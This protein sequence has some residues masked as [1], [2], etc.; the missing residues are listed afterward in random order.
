MKKILLFSLLIQAAL[1]G[2]PNII[3]FLSDDHRADLLGCAG[4]PIL[5][6]PTIDALAARGVRFEN[7]FVTTA[8]CAASRATIF[9]GLHERSHQYTFGTL[10]I[11]KSQTEAS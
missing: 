2:Q 1:A 5:K 7:S 8:I 11:R 10:P 3:F 9:T 4:H 6:T